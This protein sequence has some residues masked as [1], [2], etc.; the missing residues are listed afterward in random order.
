MLLVRIREVLIRVI[1]HDGV[2]QVG[3]DG[4]EEVVNVGV[5]RRRDFEIEGID[6]CGKALG[7]LVGYLALIGKVSLCTDYDSN[8]VV[9]QRFTTNLCLVVEVLR[10][11][12]VECQAIGDIEQYDVGV[13][14]LN[15]LSLGGGLVIFGALGVPNLK[16]YLLPKALS[17]GGRHLAA[18]G[19]SVAPRTSEG[20]RFEAVEKGSLAAGRQALKDHAECVLGLTPLTWGNCCG[21]S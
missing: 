7:F 17:E 21:E 9:L 12:R 15:E 19:G 10:A 5:D 3:E 11:H 4:F 8:R 6:F 16:L 18:H 2:D 14:G 20:V 13:G 1:H